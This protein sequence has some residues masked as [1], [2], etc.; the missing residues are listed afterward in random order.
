MGLRDSA[1]ARSPFFH[2]LLCA[3]SVPSV[4]LWFSDEGKPR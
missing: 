1:G 4:P 2:C 3:A